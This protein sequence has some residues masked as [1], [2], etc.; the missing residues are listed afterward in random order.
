MAGLPKATSSNAFVDV[1]II[2]SGTMG[3]PDWALH[4]DG[5]KEFRDCPVYAFLIEHQHLKRKVFFDL[6]LSTVVRVHRVLTSQ[7]NGVYPPNVQKLFAEDI[8]RVFPPQDN[9]AEVIKSKRG[10]HPDE[11]EEVIFR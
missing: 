10:I 6:G 3:I 11:L 8:L 7:D 9:L 4:L 1:T 2:L 5:T